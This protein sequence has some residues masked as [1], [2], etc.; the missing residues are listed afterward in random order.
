MRTRG[1]LAGSVILGAGS[2]GGQAAAPPDAELLLRTGGVWESNLEHERNPRGAYGGLVALGLEV[3]DNPVR[4]TVS[5]D[6]EVALHR[7]TTPTRWDRTSQRGGLDLALPLG[8]GPVWL[9]GGGF[10]LNGSFD[11]RE[12]GN[13]YRGG[14]GLAVML[15]P[16]L[17]LEVAGALRFKRYPDDSGRNATS[18]YAELELKRRWGAAIRLAAGARAET[19]VA[20]SPRHSYRRLTGELGLRLR[21][22]RADVLEA[23]VRLRRQRYPA[24]Q[25]EADGRRA[26]RRDAR[27]NPALG[28]THRLRE[29]LDVSLI[30][31]FE[32][33]RSNDPEKRFDAHLLSLLVTRR[34]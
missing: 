34:W 20:S 5:L 21:P 33:R 30:Y 6:Y 9:L 8:R 18:R 7:Y 2:L 26:D 31:E 16:G 24:R 3:R 17:T 27:V 29:R 19:N 11:D 13:E 22:W 4:P 32:A 12:L 10:S 14:T 25:V 28:W 1:L 23:Q 15:A